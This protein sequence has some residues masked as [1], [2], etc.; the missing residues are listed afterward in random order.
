MAGYMGGVRRGAVGGMG[1]LAQALAFGGQAERQ[2]YE[3]EMGLQSKLAQALSQIDLN[4]AQ[5]GLAE[6]GTRQKDVE[7]TF[8]Q[9]RPMLHSQLIAAQTGTDVPT[10]EGFLQRLNTG[11]APQV[12]MGPEAPDGSMGVGSMQFAPE[13]QSKMAQALTRMAPVIASGAPI[14][15]GDWAKALETFREA[16]LSGE[17]LAG[18]R[19][20]GQ[21]GRAQAAM[22]GKPLYSV[23]GMGQVV[24][25]FGGSADA[26]GAAPQARLGLTAAQEAAARAAA[27]ENRAQA[28]LA[29]ARAAEAGGGDAKKAPP[30]YRW[31]ADGTMEPIPGGPADPK[32]KR[33]GR[34][35]GAMSPTLQKELLEADD[36][37]QAGAGTIASLKAALA[38]ND[39]AYSG[40]GAKTR[41]TIRSNLPGE[42]DSADATVLMEN[43]MTG[44]GL[45]SLK[46]IFGAAPTEG[47]R[48]I[49]M[50]MQAS[51]D[52]TPAQRAEIINRAIAAAQ[53]RLVYASN[54]AKAIRDGTYL[55]T[56]IPAAAAPAGKPGGFT[57]IGKEP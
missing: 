12:P 49:L 33:E 11:Q 22:A 36:T 57:Y 50:D 37:V 18:A 56:G 31:K 17:V 6:A 14:A 42:S 53:R 55:E 47:E 19:E 52:K 40:F 16:D 4:R 46:A 2:G 45:E 41:A 35:T 23:D 39:K 24:D 3:A 13:V 9:N 28:A 43:I 51:V 20:P 25:L 1:S 29:R 27:E 32:V 21:V 48:K 15:A 44:Q 5:G 30:G 7:T 26:T 38:K 54:K 34:G 10:V 8:M